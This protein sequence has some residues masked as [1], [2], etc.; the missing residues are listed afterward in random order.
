MSVAD[1]AAALGPYAQYLFDNQDVQANL[2]R[3]VAA[4]RDAYG[5]A[6]GKKS[7]AEAVQDRQIQR[8][9]TEAAQAVREVALTLNRER[10]KQQRP[11]R[12]RVAIILGLLGAGAVAALV[13]QVRT[14]VLSL[15]A[16]ASSD[17]PSPQ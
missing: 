4:S 2:E 13:P 14:K 16:S 17:E 11:R 9:L 15:F 8:R 5:R 10:E 12:G 6:R 1:R 7:K 3:A